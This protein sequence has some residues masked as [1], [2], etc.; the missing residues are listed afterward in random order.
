VQ[1]FDEE[2]SLREL[3]GT[4]GASSPFWSPNSQLIG[5]VARNEGLLKKIE[6]VRRTGEADLPGGDRRAPRLD[7]RQ[8]YSTD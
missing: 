8:P 7:Q 5:F 3:D 2:P 4:D 6:V 1:S